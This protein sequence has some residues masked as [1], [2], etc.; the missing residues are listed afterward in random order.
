MGGGQQ[1]VEAPAAVQGAGGEQH[2]GFRNPGQFSQPFRLARVS[3]AG[4]VPGVFGDRCG[5]QG[6]AMAALHLRHRSA[7]PVEAGITA[8]GAGLAWLERLL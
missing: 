7:Q 2:R 8:G 6:L 5:D 1:G 3:V 4:C